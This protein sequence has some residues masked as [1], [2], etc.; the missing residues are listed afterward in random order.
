M[1]EIDWLDSKALSWYLY[2]FATAM[3]IVVS[4]WKADETKRGRTGDALPSA[5]DP[6]EKPK[7]F[8]EL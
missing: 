7:Y 2:D 6:E 1:K 8:E 3:I 5:V 4:G